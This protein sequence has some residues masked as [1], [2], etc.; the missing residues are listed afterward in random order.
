MDLLSFIQ[1]R[2]FIQEKVAFKRACHDTIVS[3]LTRGNS[4]SHLPNVSIIYKQVSFCSLYPQ[5]SN[6]NKLGPQIQIL[7]ILAKQEQVYSCK[8]HPAVYTVC[9]VV[10]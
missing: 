6:P 10:Y 5:F 9:P 1:V 3:H 7:V 4:Y 8:C 2:T